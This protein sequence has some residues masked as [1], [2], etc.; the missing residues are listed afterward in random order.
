MD[1]RQLDGQ[2]AFL[3][4]FLP[5]KPKDGGLA[6]HQHPKV[7]L[8]QAGFSCTAAF[9]LV[10]G[11][12]RPETDTPPSILCTASAKGRGHLVSHSALD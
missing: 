8:S 2:E 4:G 6:V 7:A 10:K 5:S 11:S 9:V 3:G 1:V 12:C